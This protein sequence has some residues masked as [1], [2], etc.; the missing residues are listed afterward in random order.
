M[1]DVQR[2][3]SKS[4][5]ANPEVTLKLIF[6]LRS[7]HDGKSEKKT[8]YH[9]FGW[10]YKYHPRTAIAN[11]PLLVA[12]VIDRPPK[13]TKKG[14]G[15]GGKKDDVMD[16]SDD[17]TEVE[18][19]EL[20]LPGYSHGERRTNLCSKYSDAHLQHFPG[21][22][23]DLLNILVLAVTEELGVSTSV[24]GSLYP[25]R[26]WWSIEDE[27][28]R[29]EAFREQ[30]AKGKAVRRSKTIRIPGRR[31]PKP[32]PA[33]GKRITKRQRRAMRSHIPES[34]AEAKA[35]GAREQ[36]ERLAKA[37]SSSPEFR[38]L[39]VA[40]ARIFA[41]K[42]AEDLASL[43]QLDKGGDELSKEER[44]AL[45]WE[46][47][48]V[49]KWAPTLGGSH[50]Q[51]TNIATAIAQVLKSLGEMGSMSVP[52]FDATGKMS[53]SP[54]DALKVRGYYRRW[55][56]SPLRRQIQIPETY[57]SSNQWQLVNYKRVP[58]VCMRNSKK[59]FFKHD[60]ERFKTYLT[61]VAKGKRSIAG[62]TLLPNELLGEAVALETALET[63]GEDAE[64]RMNLQVVEGQWNSLVDKLRESGALGNCMAI[65]DV[66]GSMGSIMS[67]RYTHPSYARSYKTMYTE[68]IFPAV[69]LSILIAKMAK[70]PFQNSFITFSLHPEVVTIDPNQGLGPTAKY[71]VGTSWEMNTN[72]QAV[73]LDLI[74][75]LAKKHNI[76]KVL[77]FAFASLSFEPVV[78]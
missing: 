58:A 25:T 63:K 8:F 37:L 15:E 78:T 3:L 47:G 2:L 9:A 44:V 52:S 21:Y 36:Y 12:P 10:L 66:S 45:K 22:Y 42:L 32:D 34:R 75:P 59:F 39:Y 68:P 4:W 70:P 18:K 53:L 51:Y 16:E 26:P 35:R 50:D 14:D 24:F 65:C 6:C 67:H 43:K 56:I 1:L 54:E 46:I 29:R 62:G 55:I 20:Q 5:A 69:A 31:L 74:L 49:G 57:M 38:A 7:I 13:K 17:W 64:L 30:A 48:L 40:V 41:K 71:M 23:K 11:L 28:Q 73:F 77:Y 33:S 19:D 61:D 76:P 60:G 27:R 72:L